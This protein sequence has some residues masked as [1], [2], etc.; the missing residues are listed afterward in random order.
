MKRLSFSAPIILLSALFIYFV[1]TTSFSVSYWADDFCSSVLLRN[2]GYWGSLISWWNNWTGR[3]SYV[4]ILSLVEMID[5]LMAKIL[6]ILL[7]FFLTIPI[8][9]IFKFEK[10]LGLTFIAL[11]FINAPNLIQT[12]YWQTGSLNYVAG[13]V[14]FNLFILNLS[15][16]NKFLAY[17][18]ALIFSIIASGFSEVYALFQ[19]VAFI[20]IFIIISL[21]DISEKKTKLKFIG[22]G[23]LSTIFSIYIMSLSPGNNARYSLTNHATSFN[24]IIVSSLYGTKWY[25][26]RMLYVK[27]FIYSL[28]LS[29]SVIY[30]VVSNNLSLFRDLFIQKRNYLFII[31]L[32]ILMAI[33]ATFVVIF[34]GYYSMNYTPP[35]RA[36]FVAIYAI[37][38]S[39]WIFSF[40]VSIYINNY[41]SL[42]VRKTILYISVF[43]EFLTSLILIINTYN[44]W[45]KI[46]E[47]LW[48]YSYNFKESENIMIDSSKT[49]SKI[50]AIKNINP[51]GG[52]DGFMENNGWVLGCV[53][54]YYNLNSV[55]LVK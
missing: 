19:L 35:E 28:I 24:S 9:T 20:F 31:V 37:F 23:I 22:V 44:N 29:I 46:R 32:S 52:L 33:F 16:P 14:F 17:F 47:N 3:Y 40:L 2:S 1:I 10:I 41:F 30:T 26:V 51:V 49:D 8:L 15:N 45:N 38:I 48:E 4:A 13:F 18:L 11:V 5:P 55:K 36:M 6:P 27:T 54:E 12:L 7:I 39:F 25:L 50:A 53:K 42:K 34:S 21:L 43:V